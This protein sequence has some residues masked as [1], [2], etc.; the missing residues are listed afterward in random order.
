MKLFKAKQF[1]IWFSISIYLLL[2]VANL[3]N[4][5]PCFA[6]SSPDANTLPVTGCCCHK[7]NDSDT[8][9][10]INDSACHCCQNQCASQKQSHTNNE[11]LTTVS[12]N[13]QKFN[14]TSEQINDSN[15]I[16]I[17][18]FAEVTRDNIIFDPYLNYKVFYRIKTVK[19]II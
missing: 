12:S 7:I 1:I 17:I 10:S 8:K 13:N 11:N 6:M 2:G 15:N 9:T 3:F 19:L 4:A 5:S 16:N 14:L 18:G